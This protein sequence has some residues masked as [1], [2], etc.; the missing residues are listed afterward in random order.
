MGLAETNI[1]E[2][3]SI[4]RSIKGLLIKMY[5][6]VTSVLRLYIYS[7]AQLLPLMPPVNRRLT[8][9]MKANHHS[10]IYLL[11]YTF[12]FTCPCSIGSSGRRT[13]DA[14]P[15]TMPS[16]G[17][18]S[19]SWDNTLYWKVVLRLYLELQRLFWDLTYYWKVVLRLYL[20]LER[21]SWNYA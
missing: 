10:M 16:I 3:Q 14:C 2:Y 1:I 15:E 17:R 19:D 21:L 7:T 5:G 8:S 12:L 18:L 6:T 13:S 4:D 20:A 9:Q 11:T